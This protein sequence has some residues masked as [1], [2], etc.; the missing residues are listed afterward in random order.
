MKALQLIYAPI[1]AD[2]QRDLLSF[3]TA[4]SEIEKS[5]DMDA[6]NKVGR[7]R[8]ALVASSSRLTEL[9]GLL[10]VLAHVQ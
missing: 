10:E 3:E 8:G 7:T 1:K 6:V 9:S 4:L 5:S 2:V